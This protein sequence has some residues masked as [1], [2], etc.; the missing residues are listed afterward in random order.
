MRGR[1]GRWAARKLLL[2]QLLHLVGPELARG[3][4]GLKVL[5]AVPEGAD[6]DDDR[7]REGVVVRV[8]FPTESFGAVFAVAAQ[9]GCGVVVSAPR[10]GLAPHS[11]AEFRRIDAGQGCPDPN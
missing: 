5:S 3:Q 2:Q 10:P 8:K 7:L 9:H 4:E 6:V 1:R 11:P